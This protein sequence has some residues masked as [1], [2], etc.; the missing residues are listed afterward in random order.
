MKMSKGL[1][2]KKDWINI[3]NMSNNF[4][5]SNSQVFNP[6]YQQSECA[7]QDFQHALNVF[8]NSD[9]YKENIVKSISKL[10]KIKG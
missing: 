9:E 7:Y 6:Y 10:E 8:V 1:M 2:L 5:T 3:L 4:A